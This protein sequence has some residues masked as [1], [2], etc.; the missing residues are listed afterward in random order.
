[1][2]NS[3]KFNVHKALRVFSE[4]TRRNWNPNFTMSFSCVAFTAQGMRRN[5]CKLS[6]TGL[7][8][9]WCNVRQEWTHQHQLSKNMVTRISKRMIKFDMGSLSYLSETK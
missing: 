4:I 3:K 8:F 7:V 5:R 9:V 2:S 6:D 1:M